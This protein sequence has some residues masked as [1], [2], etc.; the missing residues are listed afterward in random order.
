MLKKAFLHT[1][2]VCVHKYYVARL[3]FK[4]G[5]YWQGIMHDMSKFSPTEFLES[6]R[7]YK[8]TISPIAGATKAQGYSMAWL[9][10]TGRNLHHYEY[11]VRFK[12][13][14]LVSVQMPM[15]YATELLCDYIGAGMAYEGNQFTLEGEYRWWMDKRFKA[16]IHELTRIFISNCLAYMAEHNSTDLLEDKTR[17]EIFYNGE[18]YYLGYE[19]TLH[20]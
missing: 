10:H 9:H 1:C 3:C 12:G 2:K 20:R 11:W 6:I 19:K 15:K 16:P 13:M 17:L 7:Y 5:L 18:R 14:E 8:G 4:A